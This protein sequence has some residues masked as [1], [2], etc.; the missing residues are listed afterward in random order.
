MNHVKELEEEGEDI[1][2]GQQRKS[3]KAGPMALEDPKERYVRRL[4]EKAKKAKEDG[5]KERVRDEKRIREIA[6]RKKKEF[7]PK[8]G[9][10]VVSQFE[11][12]NQKSKRMKQKKHQKKLA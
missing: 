7:A 9:K 3:K 5:K 11:A 10:T 12:L 2:I 4:R 8:K 6:K 1:E